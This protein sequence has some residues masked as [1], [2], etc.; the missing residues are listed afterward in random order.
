[1][2]PLEDAQEK[3]AS[4]LVGAEEV[5]GLGLGAVC[6]NFRAG[7]AKG[8]E[9]VG[10][11]LGIG[12]EAA[13]VEEPSHREAEEEDHDDGDPSEDGELVLAQAHEG[14]RPEAGAFFE[15]GDR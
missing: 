13:D 1:M 6:T 12:V 14:V 11:V 10:E 3:V 8:R 5:E 7:R 15:V 2:S 9:A 4:E